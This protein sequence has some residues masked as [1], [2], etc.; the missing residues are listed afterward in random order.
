M[1]M[2]PLRTTPN[3]PTGCPGV[4]TMRVTSGPVGDDP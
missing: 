4:F 2:S 1:S 3:V